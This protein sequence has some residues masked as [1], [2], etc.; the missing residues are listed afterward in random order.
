MTT[1]AATAEA[2]TAE[3]PVSR[4]V[5]DPNYKRRY[6]ER[7][8]TARP[9]KGVDKKVM[10]RSNHDWLAAEL[11]K[12]VL[13]SEPNVRVTT[14]HRTKL[15]AEG[16]PVLD[17]KGKKITEELHGERV[18]RPTFEL[19]VPAFEAILDANGVKHAHWNRTTP[20]WQ[21]R[22]RMTGGLALRT[23]VAESGVLALPD[24]EALEAP[25]AWVARWAK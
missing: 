4:S 9:I 15:D 21:G 19:N 10:A 6:A 18:T 2:A 14:Y 13:R 8:K 23:K 22:L 5:V 11:A 1:E 20:G 16:N 17:D 7:A 12:R 3:A 25:K 24:G